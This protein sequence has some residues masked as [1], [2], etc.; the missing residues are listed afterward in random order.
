[1][2]W[3]FQHNRTT[4]T[5]S[6]KVFFSFCCHTTS[7]VM[8]RCLT[9][10]CTT[11]EE[12]LFKKDYCKHCLHDHSHKP[13]TLYLFE[14]KKTET[15]ASSP[16]TPTSSANV[17]VSSELKTESSPSLKLSKKENEKSKSVIL[18]LVIFSLFFRSHSDH[19][20]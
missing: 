16:S 11:F 20:N 17:G 19:C 5:N 13:A 4:P 18:L 2:K 14:Q 8:S 1:M 12:N 9:C 6:K 7:S 15:L 3:P 10:N